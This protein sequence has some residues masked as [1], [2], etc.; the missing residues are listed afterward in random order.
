MQTFGC[1][2]SVLD[3]ARLLISAQIQRHTTAPP[4]SIPLWPTGELPG[5][6]QAR[7]RLEFEPPI[8][9]NR[10]SRPTATSIPSVP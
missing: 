9:F 7:I 2:P 4:S 5:H 8:L 1:Q 3:D 6:R 10:K